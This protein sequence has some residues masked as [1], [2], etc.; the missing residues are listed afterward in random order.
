MGQL[1]MKSIDQD[2]FS[3]DYCGPLEVDSLPA[4]VA[5]RFYV[6]QSRIDVGC[7]LGHEP[8]KIREERRIVQCPF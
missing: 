4:V 3:G 8:L 1:Q 6:E 7:S 5:Q 2:Q